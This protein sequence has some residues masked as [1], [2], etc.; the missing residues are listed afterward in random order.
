MPNIFVWEDKNLSGLLVIF[1]CSIV[2]VFV[3]SVSQARASIEH[4]STIQPNLCSSLSN[5]DYSD[6]HQR[7]KICSSLKMNRNPK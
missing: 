2:V 4:C 3:I 6:V 1:I 7:K 5:S